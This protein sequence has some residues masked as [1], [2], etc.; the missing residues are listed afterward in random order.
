MGKTGL[1]YLAIIALNI[2]LL[3]FADSWREKKADV[4]FADA[5][6]TFL[7]ET[8]GFASLLIFVNK[9]TYM[10]V[11]LGATAFNFLAVAVLSFVL[12]KKGKKPEIAL[13]FS[14]DYVTGG[15]LAL[16]SII[17]I[18]NIKAFDIERIKSAREAAYNVINTDIFD[19]AST[20]AYRSIIMLTAKVGGIREM[21]LMLLVLAIC[22]GILVADIC[23]SLKMN[24]TYK[25]VTVGITMLNP[26]TLYAIKVPT[27]YLYLALLVALAIKEASAAVK[28]KTTMVFMLIPLT[29]MMLVTIKTL[30]FMPLIIAVVLTMYA[31]DQML[32]RN[33]M[34]PII[35]FIQAAAIGLLRR[36]C[37]TYVFSEWWSFVSKSNGNKP[38]SHRLIMVS[39]LA[40]I[41]LA[42]V[43]LLPAA[44]KTCKSVFADNGILKASGGISILVVMASILK[45]IYMVEESDTTGAKLHLI[46]ESLIAFIIY[47]GI[48]VIPCAIAFML[49]RNIKKPVS[50]DLAIIS[51]VFAYGLLI[52]TVAEI[53]F[54]GS[55]KSFA[56][57]MM[58]VPFM[59]YGIMMGVMEIED[60]VNKIKKAA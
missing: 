54:V 20:P 60:I 39:I 15:I 14:L 35:V 29:A 12:F 41:I 16:S 58:L 50:S 26:I 40:Y 13:K 30:F 10:R 47:T 18:L 8:T 3:W 37:N 9:Y 2:C 11:V 32:E 38:I 25:W 22:F 53:P 55:I 7:V 45:V 4:K 48:V 36:V 34:V 17:G 31:H 56:D 52:V 44:R 6:V 46:S 51:M 28:N 1:V 42:L 57:L 24:R 49:G 33:I 5:L 43:L 59:P 27:V 23:D 21:R 19:P